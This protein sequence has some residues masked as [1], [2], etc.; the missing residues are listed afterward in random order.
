MIT[1]GQEIKVKRAKSNRRSQTEA[2]SPSRE[3]ERA[4]RYQRQNNLDVVKNR[5]MNKDLKA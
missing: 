4:D 1:M 3:A 5:S 2:F